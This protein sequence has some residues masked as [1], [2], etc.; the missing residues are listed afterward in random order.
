MKTGEIPCLETKPQSQGAV[1]HRAGGVFLASF[2]LG[3]VSCKKGLVL[4]QGCNYSEG[5]MFTLESRGQ[6][7]QQLELEREICICYFYLQAELTNSL[8][9]PN[10]GSRQTVWFKVQKK[11]KGKSAA[12]IL[13]QEDTIQQAEL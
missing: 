11:D 5:R 13:K 1:G 4:S 12:N 8:R 2:V 10:R 3:I 6:L 7:K 9:T